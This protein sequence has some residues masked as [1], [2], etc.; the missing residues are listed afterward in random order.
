VSRKPLSKARIT[1]TKG[2]FVSDPTRE[3]FLHSL[4]RAPKEGL[5]LE[6][7]VWSGRTINLIADR[8]GP[9]RTVHG[10]DSFEGLPEDWIGVYSEGY[11]HTGG[12]L[13][14]VRSNVAFGGMRSIGIIRVGDS[15]ISQ[16][17]AG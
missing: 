15:L 7:G 16:R 4:E 8:V 1:Q 12:T 6:F 10:F 2:A 17:R 11:F 13:P 9:S 14:Y 5:A 3:V